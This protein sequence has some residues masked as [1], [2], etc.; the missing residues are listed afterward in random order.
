[1]S[2]IRWLIDT[3]G[4]PRFLAAYRD[5]DFEGV[6][7]TPITAL[8]G[9]WE[10]FVDALVLPP[11]AEALARSRFHHKA[12]LS[13]VCPI[14]VAHAQA[15]AAERVAAKDVAGAH[16]IYRKIIGWIPDDPQKWLPV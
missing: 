16:A 4:M 5:A 9:R 2:F 8:L 12:I 10:A 14:D 1:G 7:T 6:Y 13:R 15:E 3:G 11:E